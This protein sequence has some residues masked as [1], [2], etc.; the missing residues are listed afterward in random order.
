MPS[1]FKWDQLSRFDK[2]FEEQVEAAVAWSDVCRRVDWRDKRICRAC[3]TRSDPDAMGLTKRGHRHHIVYRSAGGQDVSSN[4]VTLCAKCHNDEHRHHLE[5]RGNADE[6]LEFWRRSEDGW[7][8][9]LD[10]RE[11]AP[12]IIEKD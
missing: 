4:L 12:G 3:G 8:W 2:K 11:S 5:I 7:Y 10:R 1:F 9:Y 6:Q